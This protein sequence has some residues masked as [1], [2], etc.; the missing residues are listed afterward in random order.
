MTVQDQIPYLYKV[1]YNYTKDRTAADDLVQETVYKAVKFANSFKEGTNIRAWLATIMRNN[2]INDYRKKSKYFNTDEISIYTRGKA[3]FNATNKGDTTMT[4]EYINN[5][6]SDL[7][8]NLSEPFL[9]HVEGYSYKEIA[10]KYNLPLGTI[11]SRIHHARKA[12][13]GQLLHLVAA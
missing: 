7:P 6:I 13:K 8:T 4:L 10:D 1:A 2:F 12:L 3:K 5:V 11:K 9:L